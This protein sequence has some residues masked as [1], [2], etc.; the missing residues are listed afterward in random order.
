MPDHPATLLNPKNSEY[1]YKSKGNEGGIEYTS[2]SSM[3][4]SCA[5]RG[6]AAATG[7]ARLAGQD[8]CTC[9]VNSTQHVN[10]TTQRCSN[11]HLPKWDT[12]HIDLSNCSKFRKCDNCCDS[13]DACEACAACAVC[14]GAGAMAAHLLGS[15]QCEPP[16]PPPCA[17]GNCSLGEGPCFGGVSTTGCAADLVCENYNRYQLRQINIETV[18]AKLLK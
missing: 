8:E 12:A 7:D 15:T 16:P 18:F 10:E 13:C 14:N 4:T 3:D 1:P 11:S 17:N 2:C 9:C 5:A 6:L